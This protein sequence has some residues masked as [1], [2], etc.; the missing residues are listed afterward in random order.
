LQFNEKIGVR[1]GRYLASGYF[2]SLDNVTLTL[3]TNED[4][5]RRRL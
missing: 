3:S 1:L 5:A 4:A 2:P